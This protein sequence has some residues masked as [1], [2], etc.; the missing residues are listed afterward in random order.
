M[1]KFLQSTLFIGL[2]GIAGHAQTGRVLFIGIDGCRGDALIAANT[3]NL[4]NLIATGTWSPDAL[5]IPPTWSGTGW[6]SMM[7]AVWPGK[8]GVTDNSF[9]G[10]NFGTYPHFYNHV[11]NSIPGVQT[12]SIVHWGPINSEILDLAD[13]EQIVGTDVAVRDAAVDRLENYDPDVLFL[14]FD[15]VDH[16]GHNY[17]F[18]PTQPEYLT[19]IETVDTQIGDVL[20]ALAGRP[21]YATEN[22]LVLVS[23]DHG[24][25]ASGH[26]GASIEEQKIFVIASGGTVPAGQVIT[27]PTTTY[28][29]VNSHVFNG[30]NRAVAAD[31]SVGNFSTADFSMECWVKTSGWIGDPSILSNKNWNSGNNAGYIIAGN[32]NGSTWKV[33]IGDGSDRVDVNGGII[34]DDQWHHLAITCDRDALL[35]VYQDGR[36]MGQ[37]SM[38]AI[39]NVDAGL[40]FC[41]AQDGTQTYFVNFDG[42][43][44]EVR[45]WEEALSQETVESHFCQEVDGT[46]PNIAALRSHWVIDEGSGT[47]LVD[48]QATSN[49]NIVGGS[50]WLASNNSMNCTDYSATPR[51]ID[52]APSAMKHLGIAID[53]LWSLDGECFGVL[54]PACSITNYSLGIQTG[55]AA[56]TGDYLQELWV[57][58]FN[59]DQWTDL[60]INGVTFDISN[61]ED[62]FLL[63]GLPADG[64]AVNLDIS[65]LADPT[66]VSSFVTAFVAPPA[67]DDCPSDLNG[68]ALVNATDLL[69]MLGAFGNACP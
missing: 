36:L 41:L 2:L 8:H 27:A 57:E 29:W 6:S 61:G 51:I 49:L 47:V 68:D 65:M 15:D 28:N 13:Y 50:N 30:T 39:G 40:N 1:L 24:G 34:N 66:C 60:V 16:A 25:T 31:P 56:L 58:Y 19:S 26:G 21:D 5:T 37:A 32:T 33:N 53:P 55:C 43:I 44:A 17:G 3:P 4:D 62:H 10:S 35:S 20:T 63:A 11:E 64:N 48:G 9:S 18:L 23:T 12:E 14:H 22:W 7:T 38:S 52:L 42:A 54:P 59:P 69:I 46:H 67:C 45:L